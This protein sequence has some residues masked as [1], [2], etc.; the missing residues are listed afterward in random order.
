MRPTFLI[1][2]LTVCLFCLYG[3]ASAQSSSGDD[4][5]R[6]A[7]VGYRIQQGDKLSVKFFTNPDL[8]EPSLTVR[9]DGY[10][11]LQI[12]DDIRAEGLTTSELKAKLEKAYDET[13]LTP[14]ITVAV[15]DFVAPHV[16]IS[17]HVGKPG[18]YELRD[19]KTLM[20][21]IFLAGGFSPDANRKMVI[22]ARPDGAG[23]WKIQSANVSEILS[24]KGTGRDITLNNG[25]YIYIPESK[26]SKFT[27]AVANIRGLL[28]RVF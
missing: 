7:P 24:R 4:T 12:I 3:S 9:P 16:F 5:S 20:E 15:I 10:I 23:D 2:S 19:A 17:G 6:S 1:L 8:N 26:M 21:A 18:R 14:I 25:D 22:H 11:S 27:K 28:P 13:L